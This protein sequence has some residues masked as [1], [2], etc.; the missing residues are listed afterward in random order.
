MPPLCW[1]TE[2]ASTHLENLS[3]TTNIYLLPFI[4]VIMSTKSITKC[5]KGPLGLGKCLIGCGALLMFRVMHSLH[6]VKNSLTF[7][8]ILG[9]HMLFCLILVSIISV[10]LLC[11][12]PCAC[13]RTICS[14]CSITTTCPCGVLHISPTSFAPLCF[15]S[16]FS[17]S[18]ACFCC[19]LIISCPRICMH[20]VFFSYLS[21]G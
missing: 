17:C 15:H 16:S 12:A 2:N 7:S 9:N 10:L 21:P 20:S 1:P 14:N 19:S 5:V 8:C 11:P 3:T 4:G 6:R 18:P 13:D